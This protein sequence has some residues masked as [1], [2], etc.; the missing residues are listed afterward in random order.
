M[1]VRL[2]SFRFWGVWA[3]SVLIEGLGSTGFKA[4]LLRFWPCM[5][6]IRIL[7][8]QALTSNSITHFLQTYVNVF[9]LS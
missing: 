7:F 4:N 6:G 8:V 3:M 9:T 1:R 2:E 5:K